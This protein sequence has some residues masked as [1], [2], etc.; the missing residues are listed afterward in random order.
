MSSYN[1]NNDSSIVF[2]FLSLFYIFSCLFI[3]S[4]YISFV[5]EIASFWKTRPHQ[6]HIYRVKEFLFVKWLSGAKGAPRRGRREGERAAWR[7]KPRAR[8][9]E[10]RSAPWTSHVRRGLVHAT[11]APHPQQSPQRKEVFLEGVF[12]SLNPRPHIY[13][14]TPMHE[15]KS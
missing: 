3:T 14:A 9:Q 12:L 4:I 15:H 13:V 8:V 7:P 11:T 2:F 10:V 1:K 5:K 6:R